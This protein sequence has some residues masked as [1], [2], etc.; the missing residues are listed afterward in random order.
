M[1]GLLG[2]RIKEFECRL[3]D[4][5]VEIGDADNALLAVDHRRV[6]VLAVDLEVLGHRP[7]GFAGQRSFGHLL[8]H[9]PEFRIHVREPGRIGIGVG[10]EV[11]KTDIF[12]FVVALCGGHRIVCL[13]KMPFAGEIGLVAASL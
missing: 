9:G 8:E 12:H 3:F 13:A 2:S 10:V 4:I 7:A 6:D 5:T 11:V 1:I